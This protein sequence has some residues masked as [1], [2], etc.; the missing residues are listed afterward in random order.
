MKLDAVKAQYKKIEMALESENVADAFKLLDSLAAD[1]QNFKIK[2]ELLRL[3]QTYDYILHYM[4]EGI[5]DPTRE[6][7]YEAVVGQLKMMAE[8]ILYDKLM[9]ES[10]GVYFSTA[11]VIRHRN[12][13]LKLLFD[14]Y[15][16]LEVKLSL[17]KAAG[18]SPAKMIGEKDSILKEIFN[19][20]WTTHNDRKIRP[21]V[22]ER[23]L[24]GNNDDFSI[25]LISAL[26]LSLL[27]YYDK[28]KLEIL[29]DVY[30]K[31]EREAIAGAALTALVFAIRRHR[32]D[33]SDDKSLIRRLE[34]WQDSIVTYSRLRDIVKEIIRTRDTDRVT[35]KMRDEVMPELM[36]LRPD[37]VK[38][39]RES[40][41]DFEAMTIEDNPEWEEI[42]EKNGLAQKMQ[43][44]TEMQSEGADL[45]MVTF[46]SLKGFPFFS[47]PEAWFLPF[48]I[49]NPAIHLDEKV[50]NTLDSLLRIGKGMCDSDKYSLA[51]A[52]GSMPESQKNMMLSQLD[53]QLSQLSEEMKE[54]IQKNSRPEF[55]ESVLLFIRQLYRFFKLYRCKGEFDD[56]FA[57]PFDFLSLPVAGT[58]MADEEI[59]KI[60][61]EF[62]FKRG[63][64]KEA[65]GLF[66]KLE[67][68]LSQEGDYWEKVGYALQS[69]GK[70]DE[71]EIAYR[72]AELLKEPSQW[73]LKKLAFILRK[74]GKSRDAVEY[75]ERV[76]EGDPDNV[77]LIMSTGYARYDSGDV[78]G[79][80]KDYYHANYLDPDNERI[81]R[82]LA[83]AELLLGN[84]PKSINF[85]TKILANHPASTD[86]LNAGHA[87]L[88]SGNIKQAYEYY[89]ISSNDDMNAFEMAFKS[90][91]EVL[92]KLGVSKITLSLLLDKLKLS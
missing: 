81:W 8:E 58:M 61:S 48:D 85:Y 23:I 74:N 76:L 88:V 79:A 46:S 5:E 62:Y 47:S 27:G 24:S 21:I 57:E 20:L 31:T 32:D 71:A 50:R 41:S 12:P 52:F 77:N 90:D 86:Y 38:K 51:L 6:T 17:S 66:K 55:N 3:R 59:L 80:V 72:K 18:Q 83:W 82:A 36:K 63:Y 13:D 40:G 10:T 44:L 29:L 65:L 42:L 30:E 26:T 15:S 69:L 2:D 75:Y 11:R 73:L 53:G 56:P 22:S 1:E 16:D 25:F 60:T 9:E 91:Y 49:D 89:S 37:I 70:Y 7:Q 54:Q 35:A 78:A 67:P 28:T 87:Q 33:I 92:E 45:M 19:F 34:L 68:S 43:E 84:S 64:F 39:L 4:L 14:N